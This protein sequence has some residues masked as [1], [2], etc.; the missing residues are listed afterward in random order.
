MI[1]KLFKSALVAFAGLL[2][3]GAS[4]KPKTT[5]VTPGKRLTPANFHLRSVHGDAKGYGMAFGTGGKKKSNRLRYSHNAKV[6]RR[7]A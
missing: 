6:K 7:M 1:R 4:G 2:S 5:E 3:L